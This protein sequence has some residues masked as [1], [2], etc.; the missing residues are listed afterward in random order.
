M[1]SR[2]NFHNIA[3]C[4]LSALFPFFAFFQ[5]T[6]IN[7]VSPE[8][9]SAL[10]FSHAE[11]G[12]LSSAYLYG[13]TLM[14][15]PAGLLLDRIGTKRAL[16]A[17]VMLLIVGT[18]IF[19]FSKSIE[20]TTLGR[21][22]AGLGHGFALISSFRVASLYLPEKMRGRMMSFILTIAFL[23]GLFA[24]GPFVWIYERIGYK[25]AM[26]LQL[27]LGV[28]IFLIFIFIFKLPK[29]EEV[30]SKQETLKFN[31]ALL[32]VFK[33]KQN[34]LSIGYIVL[35]GV[36]FMLLG[37]VFGTE[38]LVQY[39][40]LSVQNASSIVGLIF[41]GI[42]IGTPVSGWLYDK[43]G[44]FKV[45]ALISSLITLLICV[46][47]F[48]STINYYLMFLLLGIFSS[49]QS[50][51]YPIIANNNPQE[52]TSTAMGMANFIIMLLLAST[53][54]LSGI[55]ASHSTLRNSLEA[56]IIVAIGLSIVSVLLMR[57]S[58]SF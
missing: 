46:L 47:I 50:L 20:L 18:A 37:A 3:L 33:N 40:N 13:D 14:L 45:V 26:S 17:G 54:L 49:T 55:M 7:S 16:M 44:S 51:G 38:Y 22:I 1:K 25:N 57:N 9:M 31:Q 2:Q 12:I 19:S 4:L 56:I 6:I 36:P 30:T 32:L 24:Q 5:M 53:Q 52:I 35:M 29:N 41:L 23:G 39:K 48:K 15:I 34:W 10:G 58:K 28:A 43:L 42:I 21:F 11:L 8:L 27:L